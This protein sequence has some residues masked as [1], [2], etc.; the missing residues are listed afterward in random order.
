MK[1]F[2]KFSV[3]RHR[4]GVI[5]ASDFSEKISGRGKRDLDRGNKFISDWRGG[6][7]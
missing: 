3:K 1:D 7:K 6:E 5:F 4:V 2:E